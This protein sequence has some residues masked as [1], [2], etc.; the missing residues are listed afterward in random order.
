MENVSLSVLPHRLSPLTEDTSMITVSSYGV[1]LQEVLSGFNKKAKTLDIHVHFCGFSQH[2]FVFL[3]TWGVISP[4]K[5][6]FKV[7]T[8]T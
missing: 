5:L 6:I 8:T 7:P 2:S 1:K 4:S 3:S